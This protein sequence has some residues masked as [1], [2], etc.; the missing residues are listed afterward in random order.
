[1]IEFSY[2][3]QFKLD[4]E[5]K[6]SNWISNVIVEEG[7]VE[8]D[9]CYVFCDD[10]YLH[11][12]NMEY[13]HHD[14]LTDIISF[15]YTLGKTVQGDIFISVERVSDNAKDFGVTFYNELCRVII[16]GV[17]HYCGFKDKTD[18]ERSIMRDKEDHY[19]GQLFKN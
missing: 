10:N 17:L 18:E 9:I 7:F 6:L 2:E 13:L 12:L 19:I 3:T 8:G 15:D 5:V 14:T 1:M 16:H 4:D 11:K